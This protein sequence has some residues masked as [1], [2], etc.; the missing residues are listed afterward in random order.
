MADT[1]SWAEFSP[2]LRNDCD[3]VGSEG[4]LRK[5]TP[6]IDFAHTSRSERSRDLSISD[7]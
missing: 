2:K 1:L 5:H 3:V 6:V 4:N 7:L